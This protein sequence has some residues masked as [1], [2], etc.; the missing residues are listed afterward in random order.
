[1]N[2]PYPSSDKA[3]QATNPHC[4]II[5]TNSITPP[6]SLF[7]PTHSTQTLLQHAQ[8]IQIHPCLNAPYQPHKNH[9][10]YII[11]KQ[12]ERAVQSTADTKTRGKNNLGGKIFRWGKEI[13]RLS[14]YRRAPSFLCA[15]LFYR[16]KS[17][18]WLSDL[19][20][21]IQPLLPPPCPSLLSFP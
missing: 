7:N 6:P 8:P 18:F 5:P 19:Y 1:M 15:S 11:P 12:S 20:P 21:Q 17:A 16:Y 9:T 3:T 2:A 10:R 13:F 4:Q 14:A